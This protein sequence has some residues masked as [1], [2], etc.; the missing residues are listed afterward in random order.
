MPEGLE[1]RMPSLV[2][3][4]PGVRDVQVGDEHYV[5][6]IR[7]VDTSSGTMHVVAARNEETTAL[8]LDRLHPATEQGFIH[9]RRLALVR[10]GMDVLAYQRQHATDLDAGL[11]QS[12]QQGGR[13]GRMA[14]VPIVGDGIGAG[15][16]G[17]QRTGAGGI[18]PREAA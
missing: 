6:L 13:E 3:R 10:G 16:E 17:H 15:G 7:S 2:S 11:R 1:D 4:G 8:L 18:E 5:V 14:V 12:L 9:P